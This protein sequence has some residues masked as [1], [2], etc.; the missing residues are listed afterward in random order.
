MSGRQLARLRVEIGHAPGSLLVRYQKTT[1]G[2][3]E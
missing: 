3:V 1:D 2:R